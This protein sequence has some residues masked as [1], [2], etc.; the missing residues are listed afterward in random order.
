MSSAMWAPQRT[1]LGGSIDLYTPDLPGFGGAP[2]L[3]EE[4][5]SMARVALYVESELDAR[6]IERCVLGGLSMGGYVTLACLRTM[7][8]RIA[9]IVL[10]DTR[11]AADDDETRK[12]RFA[13][14][15]RIGAGEYQ[16]Y[17]E[18]LLVK[19]LAESTRRTRPD[20]VESVRRYMLD[21]HPETAAAA[22]MGMAVRPDSRELLSVIDVPTAVIV[23]EHDA[24]TR[25]EEA[26]S[27]CDAI[28]GATLHVIANAGHMSNIENAEAFNE[29]VTELMSRVTSVE[30]PQT[31]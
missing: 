16:S 14:M 21:V 19:L 12:G 10:A 11:A 13:A 9:G 17:C 28:S 22:L 26:R 15:E 27:M 30:T 25:V 20:I 23:G 31:L 6:G 7:R 24:I 3:D 29:A 8:D 5:F 2:G 18:T 1:G 4:G